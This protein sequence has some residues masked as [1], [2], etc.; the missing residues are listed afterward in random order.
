MSGSFNN[1]LNQLLL[2]MVLDLNPWFIITNLGDPRLWAVLCVILFFIRL[3]YRSKVDHSRKR[4]KWVTTFIIFAGFAMASSLG[5]NE[6]LKLVFQIPRACSI[7]TNPYCLG[8]YSFPSG[9]TAVAFAVFAGIF[10]ILKNKKY[11]WVFVLPILVGVSRV[12]LSVHTVY[13]VAT[14]AGLGLLVFFIYLFAVKKVKF[15]SKN[16]EI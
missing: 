7:E 3:Y 5:V 11:W 14:G 4:Y 6:V 1:E 8:T 13:D 12:A 15:I 9:H 2:Y 10:Y 16:V